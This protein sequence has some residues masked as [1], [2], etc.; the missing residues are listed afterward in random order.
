MNSFELNKIMGAILGTCL[1][2]MVTNFAAQAVFSPKP[3]EK[4]GYDIAVKEVAAGD[5]KAAAAPAEPI[6]K[7]LQTA[8]VEKGATAAKKCGACHTFEKGGPNRVGPNLFGVVNDHVGQGR[9][10]FNFSA[11]MKAKGGTWTFEDLN[12]FINNPK[13]TVPGT[14]M[15]F[16]G[17]Q[18]DSER[19]DVIAYLASLADTPVPLPTAAK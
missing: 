15:G 13:G 12:K 9:N 5:A 2:L 8:S 14:A 16:A 19:A 3:V 11:A 6:E 1:L 7:L 18:K 10:G 17:I 4:P